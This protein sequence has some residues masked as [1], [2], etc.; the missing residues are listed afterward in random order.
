[1][2]V[3]CILT[4]YALSFS[5][6]APIYKDELTK[7]NKENPNYEVIKNY[8]R[9]KPLGIILIKLGK[10]KENNVY[11]TLLCNKDC[12]IYI[13]NSITNEF[14]TVVKNYEELEKFMSQYEPSK[15]TNDVNLMKSIKD[16]LLI[17]KENDEEEKKKELSIVLKQQAF[18]KSKK[19]TI[20]LSRL[21]KSRNTIN[22]SIICFSTPLD[23]L[24]QGIN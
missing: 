16:F 20:C 17:Y 5:G 14:S 19:V 11:Y 12:R 2:Q 1:M 4:S 22:Q 24:S 18:E 10:D 13:E 23:M 9:I 15:N 3:K 21:Q 7:D 8:K 6:R